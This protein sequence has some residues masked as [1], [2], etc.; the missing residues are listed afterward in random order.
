MSVERAVH[1]LTGELAAWL[2]LETGVLAPGKRAD[3]AIV[4]P[5]QLDE[6]LEVAHEATAD[7]YGAYARLVRRNDDA[8]RAV[9]VGGRVAAERGALVA[10]VGKQRGFGRV[11]RAR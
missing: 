6:R 2:G 7:G 5:A 9:I 3:V 1:R 8:V 10:S 4:D 11:L